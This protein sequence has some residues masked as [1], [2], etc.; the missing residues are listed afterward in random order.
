MASKPNKYQLAYLN[1]NGT[2]DRSI[3]GD[4]YT[5]C[6]CPKCAITQYRYENPKLW[7]KAWPRLPCFE[8]LCPECW[9][10]FCYVDSGKSIPSMSRRYEL[11]TTI[12]RT[13]PEL[14]DKVVQDWVNGKDLTNGV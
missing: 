7:A 13:S 6:K 9:Q 14:A 10:Q 11:Y 2:W 3:R 5:E 4:G 1:Q 12:S 8:Q